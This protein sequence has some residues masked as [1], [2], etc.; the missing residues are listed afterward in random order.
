MEFKKHILRVLSIGLMLSVFSPVYAADPSREAEVK[1]KKEEA[2]QALLDIQRFSNQTRIWNQKVEMLL[3]SPLE[4]DAAMIAAASNLG[5][6]V[7]EFDK[8]LFVA[9][10]AWERVDRLANNYIL[11]GRDLGNISEEAQIARIRIITAR[12]SFGTLDAKFRRDLELA[13]ELRSRKMAAMR[14]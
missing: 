3:N 7:W 10:Q 14:K 8:E 13:Q 5:S 1:P 6:I 4:N 9:K 11:W 2:R 12:E